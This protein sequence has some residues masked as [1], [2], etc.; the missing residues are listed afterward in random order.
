MALGFSAFMEAD[1]CEFTEALETFCK[2]TNGAEL[3]CKDRSC[4]RLV[5]VDAEGR[6]L[7]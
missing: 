6:K 7:A 5:D 1:G 2:G 4:G 3:E